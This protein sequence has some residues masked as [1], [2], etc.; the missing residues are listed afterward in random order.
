MLA[1]RKRLERG[2][3]GLPRDVGTE[4]QPEHKAT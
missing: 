2:P 3:M 4:V 1:K